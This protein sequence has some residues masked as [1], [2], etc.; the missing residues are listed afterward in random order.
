MKRVLFAVLGTFIGMAGLVLLAT[1][2]MLLALF[3]TD[4]RADVPI[5]SV[6]SD[7]GR[8]VLVNDFQIDAP[9]PLPAMDERWLDLEL[10]VTGDASHFVGV[11]PKKQAVRY[12]QGVPYDLVTGID[13]SAD[14]FNST[15][16][17]G[18]S[19]PQ[20]PET[21]SWQEQAVGTDV[22]VQWPASEVDTS[23]VVMN[24]DLSA[25]V[26]ATVDVVV[27]MPWA[28]GAGIGMVIGGVVAVILGIVLLVLAMRS[29]SSKQTTQTTPSQG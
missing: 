14:S 13:S 21:M 4:G 10:R 29:K 27:K 20:P 5:G 1:G 6:T 18:S 28:S 19:K 16:I 15:T 25:D 24:E 2:G 12:L 3:G 23:L 11:A 17:P 9:S 22:S 26:S 8:A 7:R